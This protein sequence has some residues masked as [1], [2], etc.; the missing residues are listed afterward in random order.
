[1][2]LPT[3]GGYRLLRRLERGGMAEVWEA[4]RDGQRVALKRLLVHDTRGD[5]SERRLLEE[6]RIGMRLAHPNLVRVLAA[7]NE[8]EPF[9]VMELLVGRTLAALVRSGPLPLGFVLG[10]ALQLLEGLGYAH[11]R[12][13]AH[14]GLLG[15]LH[16]DLKPSNLFVTL[17][18]VAKVIDFGISKM[19]G[20]DQTDTQTGL[21]RGSLPY[22]APE[23]LRH[24]PFL[25]SSDL[26]SFGL[27]L[28]ELLTGKRVF[29]Q[30]GE[31]A[32]LSAIL[33]S[34]IPGIRSSR[35]EVPA[36]LD[37]ALR[38]LLDKNPSARPATAADLATQLR[39]AVDPGL[40]WDAAQL[41][42]YVR[43]RLQ[44]DVPETAEAV[45]LS[46][47]ERERPQA[48]EPSLRGP[49]RRA[50]V[51]GALGLGAFAA[52]LA[53][54]LRSAPAPR[55]AAVAAAPARV[56]VPERANSV[57]VPTNA[58]AALGSIPVTPA[59]DPPHV[60]AT[61]KPKHARPL[62]WLTAG[63]RR[64]WAQVI[65][66][67]KDLG[68]TPLFHHPLPPGRH[69]LESVRPDGT[70][71]NRVVTVLSNEEVKIAIP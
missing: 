23:I 22:T 62:G 35:E 48:P 15:L 64:G 68:P 61:V 4:E 27:V 55:P 37:G 29:A 6:A 26:F 11:A 47:V 50:W 63:T 10:A 67:G 14:G 69:H 9:L 16:R 39:A 7:G 42:E 2:P 8:P 66:D 52:T 20:L 49:R 43:G 71:K 18:G 36:A 65:V 40:I 53:L 57:T 33:W 60:G 51:G 46:D 70:R 19:H 5:S 31:A 17:D 44:R 21:L 45:G 3:L 38:R 25:P 56:T 28:H 59:L 32:I 58:S 24:E 30:L 12:T 13:D 54:S 1:M 41:G 34:P